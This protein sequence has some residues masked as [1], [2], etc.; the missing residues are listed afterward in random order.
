MSTEELTAFLAVFFDH[1]MARGRSV[2]P[3][4]HPLNVL[5]ET[6]K[7]SPKKAEI[8]LRMAVTD[9]LEMS[10]PWTSS[11]VAEADRVLDSN[12]VITLSALRHR[13]RR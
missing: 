4:I 10:L 3:E 2:P 6:G 11:Q 1:Y 5:R 13:F 9:C 7:K 12:G 8:G